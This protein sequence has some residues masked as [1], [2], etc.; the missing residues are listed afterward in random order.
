[1]AEQNITERLK[2]YRSMMVKF[3]GDECGRCIDMLY[4]LFPD[5]KLEQLFMLFPNPK[6][7][8]RQDLTET[9]KQYR[10]WTCT[11]VKSKG[12]KKCGKCIDTLYNLFP[13]LE[14]VDV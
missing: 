2:Q 6:L 5:P 7:E 11:M 8:Q 3:H 1:M 9:M 10:D 13:E 12:I 14:R 4:M